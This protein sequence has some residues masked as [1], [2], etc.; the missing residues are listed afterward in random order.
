[1]TDFNVTAVKPLPPGWL[2][3]SWSRTA[4]YP[5]MVVR[6]WGSCGRRYMFDDRREKTVRNAR[7]TVW[8]QS[9]EV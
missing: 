2:Y 6:G 8:D 5:T 7:R 1:M 9:H 4:E 3:T